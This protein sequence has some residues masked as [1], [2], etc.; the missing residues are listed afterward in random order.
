ML[1]KEVYLSKRSPDQNLGE[2]CTLYQQQLGSIA[3][4]HE[5]R[6]Q[7]RS[8]ALLEKRWVMQL[9]ISQLLLFISSGEECDIDI[10][11][12]DSNPC[13]HAGTCLDQPNGYT[14]HCPHGWVGANCEIRKFFCLPAIIFRPPVLF[15]QERDAG[16][17]QPGLS[18]RQC[19]LSHHASHISVSHFCPPLPPHSAAPTPS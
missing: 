16:R 12:C 11:E 17:A 14:C 18:Q 3:G 6:A 2:F 15:H 4:N 1:L 5:P 19:C 10:N 13:H 9:I 8:F 7:I